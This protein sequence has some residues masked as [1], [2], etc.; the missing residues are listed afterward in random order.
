MTIDTDIRAI[1]EDGIEGN[2]RCHSPEELL[3]VMKLENV[4]SCHIAVDSMGVNLMNTKVNQTD[5]SN[6]IEENER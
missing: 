4:T 6:W 5:V 3:R 2:I 1:S